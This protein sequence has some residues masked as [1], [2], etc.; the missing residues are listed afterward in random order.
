MVNTVDLMEAIK[1][2]YGLSNCTIKPYGPVWKITSSQGSF[3]L[4]K[5]KVSPNKLTWTA[6]TIQRLSEAGFPN[7]SPFIRLKNQEP[8][9]LI[10]Q[11]QYILSM[12]YSGKHPSFSNL[13]DLKTI[14]RLYGHLHQTSQ[15]V[16]PLPKND[17]CDFEQ[18]LMEKYLFLTSL[19]KHF[20]TVQKP[21]RID[22]SLMKWQSYFIKQAE[23]SL[24][25]L[26]K[27]KVSQ[28]SKETGEKGFCHK[29]PAPRN[30]IVQNPHWIIIDYELSDMDFF[31]SELSTLLHRALT[32][33]Q[34]EIE[35]VEPLLTAYQ[36]SRRLTKIEKQLLPYLIC[37]PRQYWRICQQRYEENLKWSESHFQSKLW[38]LSN[39]EK[40]RYQLLKQ[41]FPDI[42]LPLFQGVSKAEENDD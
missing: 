1:K 12:W 15:K 39:Q 17:W 10:N 20:L 36:G 14:F 40:K 31:I 7:L 35:I 3:M 18:V 38:D 29:D 21:N 32:A 13:N 4:K 34:W 23:L 11:E 9:I 33:N 6:D 16:I 2:G 26:H 30:I 41:W 27:L 25:G 42:T 24:L 5:M 28:W 37:F 8:F 19:D 22:R